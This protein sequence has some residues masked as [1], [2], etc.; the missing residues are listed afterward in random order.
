MSDLS[1]AGP[2]TP[3]TRGSARLSGVSKRYG[4]V[5]ALSHVDLQLE[6]GVTA[7]LGRNGAGKSTLVRLL[8]GVEQPSTGRI[9]VE[10]ADPLSGGSLATRRLIGWLPQAFG[11]PRAMRV[12][13][14]VA[15][16]GWLKQVPDPRAAAAA[17]MTFASVTDVADRRLGTLSGGTLRRVGLAAAVTHAPALLV[18]DEPTT[19]LDPIQRAG[20]HERVAELGRTC[21]VLIATH[22]LEDVA[23]LADR[24]KVLDHGSVVWEGTTSELGALGGAAGDDVDHLRA[25]FTRLVGGS[26]S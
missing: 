8:V 2:G 19:G 25:G 6:P 24:V 21:T 18:L 12:R 4:A 14:F 22:I 3:S 26:D 1:D 20:L 16:A 7:L 11:F 9:T 5:E 13:D 23:A 15:Y 10:G 17:A